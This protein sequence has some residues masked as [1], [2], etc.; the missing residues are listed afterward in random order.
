[1]ADAKGR[2]Y[3]RTSAPRNRRLDKRT[4]LERKP[5]QHVPYTDFTVG[6]PEHSNVYYNEH[7]NFNAP[8][9][10]PS[11]MGGYDEQRTSPDRYQA[12]SLSSLPVSG[13]AGRQSRFDTSK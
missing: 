5:M 1:M 10:T 3:C 13:L 12:Q 9:Y 11:K 8:S 6:D 4:P 7:N 2:G